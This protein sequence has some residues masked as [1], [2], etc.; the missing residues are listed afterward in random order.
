MPGSS[1]LTTKDMGDPDNTISGL[2][3]PVV[4]DKY[5]DKPWGASSDIAEDMKNE[6]RCGRRETDTKKS[7]YNKLLAYQSK[8][9]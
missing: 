4:S 1:P 5:Y 3:S 2:N 8:G 7:C 6:Y 9:S